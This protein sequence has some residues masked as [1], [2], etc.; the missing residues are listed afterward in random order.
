MKPPCTTRPMPP[1]RPWRRATARTV[2]AGMPAR[3]GSCATQACRDSGR[4]WRV[5]TSTSPRV[6]CRVLTKPSGVIR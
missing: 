6:A 2:S 1:S 5:S 4:P 3:P